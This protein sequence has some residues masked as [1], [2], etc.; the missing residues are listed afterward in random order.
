MQDFWT[1]NSRKHTHQCS[2]QFYIGTF[3][4]QFLRGKWCKMTKPKKSL[5]LC[6]GCFQKWG[7]FGRS[8]NWLD[9]LFNTSAC[10]LFEAL[11]VYMK[12]FIDDGTLHSQVIRS[13]FLLSCGDI[14]TIYSHMFQTALGFQKKPCQQLWIFGYPNIHH[15]HHISIL[16]PLDGS[17]GRVKKIKASQKAFAAILEAQ[18]WVI[19]Y[20]GDGIMV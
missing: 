19:V 16:G 9:C 15:I 14:A 7:P 1:I 18:W 10:H 5:P 6:C 8:P 3:R 17:P 13:I 12:V 2:L 20:S 11:W 4:C